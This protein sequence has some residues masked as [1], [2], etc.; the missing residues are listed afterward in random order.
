MSHSLNEDMRISPGVQQSLQ[1]SS[2]SF[3]LLTMALVGSNQ[4]AV[5]VFLCIYVNVCLDITDSSLIVFLP[6][7]K[8]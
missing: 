1:D 2:L 5:L 3:E 8:N 4:T 7:F 6:A